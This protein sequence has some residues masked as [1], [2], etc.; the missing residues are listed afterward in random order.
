MKILQKIWKYAKI[1]YKEPTN[2]NEPN[3]RFD[4]FH[5]NSDYFFILYTKQETIISFRGTDNI[6]GWISDLQAVRKSPEYGIHYGFYQ[7]WIPLKKV[8]QENSY[9]FEQQKLKPLFITGHSRGGVFAQLTARML[10]KNYGLSS[11]CITFGA[12]RIGGKAFR[13]DINKMAIDN[14]RVIN[15]WDIVASLPLRTMGYHHAGHT[16]VLKQPFYHRLMY[17]RIK[18]HSNYSE[19]LR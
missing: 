17:F 16:Y 12:P 6:R 1:T 14:T 3:I 13:D 10:H 18:D 8:L 4:S 19:K 7:S 9:F 11:S 5:N 15:G 2:L